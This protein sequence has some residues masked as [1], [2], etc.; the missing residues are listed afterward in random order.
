MAK[1]ER[2]L[3]AL[4]SECE[5]I[6][7]GQ[8]LH[9]LAD[10]KDDTDP[11]DIYSD[12][13]NLVLS[14]VPRDIPP[15]YLTRLIEARQQNEQSGGG[16]QVRIRA[17]VDSEIQVFRRRLKAIRAHYRAQGGAAVWAEIEDK[18]RMA[19]HALK[20]ASVALNDFTAAV[21]GVEEAVSQMVAI[22]REHNL[23][24]GRS[25]ENEFSV[26]H[27]FLKDFSES[28]AKDLS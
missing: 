25:G 16:R 23:R 3:E 17:H 12:D 22:E 7:K 14:Q 11:A 1:I 27:H 10:H 24:R 18:A 8:G 5:A 13:G 20:G 4:S 21:A 9:S 6:L 26:C 28:E 15:Y 19:Y 2:H